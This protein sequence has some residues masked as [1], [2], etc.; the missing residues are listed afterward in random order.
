MKL[1]K[2]I[3]EVQD[4]IPVSMTSTIRTVQ[5]YFGIAERMIVQLIGRAQFDALVA[6]YEAGPADPPAD[7]DLKL[8]D[9]V[10]FAQTIEVNLGYYFATPILSVNI[11]SGG[12]TINSNENTKQ[13]FN[14]QVSDVRRSLLEIGFNSIEELL[15]LME[16]NPAVFPD[17]HA[18]DEYK[19]QNRYLIKSAAVFSDKF[20]IGGSRYVFHC[21]AYIMRRVE[22]QDVEPLFGEAFLEALKSSVLSDPY[23]KLLDEFLQPG[24]ALLTAAK[25]LRERV[26]TL[27]RGVATINL[28]GN[29]D[30][31][32]KQQVA[33]K[34]QMDDMYDQLTADGNKFLSAGM[35]YVLE[36]TDLFPDYEEPEAKRGFNILSD[37]RDKGIWAN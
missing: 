23:K 12:I 25:A 19:K 24:I 4:L 13:A 15:E 22:K 21:I 16:N 5:S 14:W 26:I 33:E 10:R 31:A 28:E 37:K 30:T 36:N 20:E 17:Y 27:E 18:S 34:E 2:T 7:D 32:K 8:A 6:A 9:A 29:Y 35:D 1:I 11:G 3:E